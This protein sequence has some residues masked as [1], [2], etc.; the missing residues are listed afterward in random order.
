M[1]TSSV[2]PLSLSF[3]KATAI[4]TFTR[5]YTFFRLFYVFLVSNN[6]LIWPF[7]DGRRNAQADLEGPYYVVGA[8]DRTIADGK[9][10]MADLEELKG[11]QRSCYIVLRKLNNRSQP[12]P[13]P[14]FL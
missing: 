5:V 10:L 9:V 6:P 7:R 11:A 3:P 2:R 4:S 13:P 12:P 14:F 8:P 1:S